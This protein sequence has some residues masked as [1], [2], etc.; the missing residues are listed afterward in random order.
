MVRGSAFG[1]EWR[2]RR[3]AA[4]VPPVSRP[5]VPKAGQPCGTLLPPNAQGVGPLAQASLARTK[6]QITPDILQEP[7]EDGSRPVELPR[8]AWP[9]RGERARFPETPF[10]GLGGSIIMGMHCD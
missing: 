6:E 4:I 10:V 5:T 8:A 2:T 3:E 7:E 9:Y 1:P